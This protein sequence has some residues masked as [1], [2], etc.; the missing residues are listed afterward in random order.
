MFVLQATPIDCLKI[1]NSYSDPSNG[2]LVSF[3]GLVRSDQVESKKV[4]SLLYIADETI[5]T[6]EG[7]LIINQAIE[8]FNLNHAVCI[9]R[10]GQVEVLHTAIWIGAWAPHREDAFSGCRFIIEETKRRLLI[11]K[12]EFYNNGTSAWIHGAQTPVII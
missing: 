3:E 10:I 1:K 7:S 4:A 11:W 2:A 6:Q 8:K 9:Q 12:K 5:C